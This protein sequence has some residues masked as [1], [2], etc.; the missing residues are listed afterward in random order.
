MKGNNSNDTDL[1]AEEI[2]KFKALL[3]AKRSEILGDLVSMEDEI[4]LRSKSDSS[5][6]SAD[7]DDASSD[8]YEM[9]NT[10]GLM[11]SEI[12]L[13]R[14]IDEALR[15]IENGTYGICE[16]NDKPIPRARLEAIPWAKYC[17]EYASMLEKNLVRKKPLSSYTGYNYGDDEP[18]DNSMETY[19]RAAV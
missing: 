12:R 18:D 19:R 2:S 11:D 17:V 1:T 5:N 9:E 8:N 4:G 7:M 16:G 3:Q 6:M 10:L 13:I 14:E 15:R